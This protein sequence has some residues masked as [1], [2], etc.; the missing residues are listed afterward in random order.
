MQQAIRVHQE[1]SFADEVHAFFNGAPLRGIHTYEDD[2]E[3]VRGAYY[4]HKWIEK[5]PDYYIIRNEQRLFS[6][7]AQTII[8]R[9]GEHDLLADIGC[10]HAFS[11]KI[12]HLLD[13]SNAG[14]L[15]FDSDRTAVE[16]CFQEAASRYPGRPRYRMVGDFLK[17]PIRL[18]QYGRV[19]PVMLGGTITN[20]G[21]DGIRTIL[22]NLK[23][24]VGKN[25]LLLT[26][27][28]NRNPQSIVRAYNHPLF[29]LH[30]LSA[31][32][33]I[34]RDL[35]TKGFHVEDWDCET[36]W[37]ESTN[38]A[39]ITFFPKRDVSFEVSGVPYDFKEGRPF[40]QTS[41]LKL[42]SDVFFGGS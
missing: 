31:L 9:A 24:L 21:V 19:F 34:K 37:N 6:E 18:S 4:F 2:H 38:T 16:H 13:E 1:T 29:K 3:S 25:G 36:V 35:P 20:F 17:A 42:P 26:H 14:Y 40:V 23:P 11:G 41:L 12:A 10:G 27:D 28:A 32:H 5:D 15:A 30:A 39:D 22:R 33:K 7:N 8:E